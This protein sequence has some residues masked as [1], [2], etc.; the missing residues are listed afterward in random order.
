MELFHVCLVGASDCSFRR[1]LE[2]SAALNTSALR[3]SRKAK[4]AVQVG[5]D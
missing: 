1:E 5:H 4:F 2:K 3:K